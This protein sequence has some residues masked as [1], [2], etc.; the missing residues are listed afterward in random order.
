MG[1]A[2]TRL[3]GL[4]DIRPFLPRP[5][6]PHSAANAEKGQLRPGEHRAQ[7]AAAHSTEGEGP[8]RVSFWG[9]SR[10]LPSLAPHRSHRT[11][12]GLLMARHLHGDLD[13]LQRKSCSPNPGAIKP[14]M[15]GG[16]EQPPRCRWGPTLSI[17]LSLA[18]TSQ[19]KGTQSSRGRE[20]RIPRLL[21]DVTTCEAAGVTLRCAGRS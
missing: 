18:G 21:E 2:L 5:E 10:A 1:S 16:P 19:I 8:N 3:Q 4:P 20:A 14:L 17:F 15:S 13:H 11:G 6:C 9:A 7:G 12:Q